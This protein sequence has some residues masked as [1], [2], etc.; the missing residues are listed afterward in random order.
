MLSK[1]KVIKTFCLA[2]DFCIFFDSSKIQIECEKLIQ[3]FASP[4]ELLLIFLPYPKFNTQID[5]IDKFNMVF[6][7]QVII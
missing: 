2:D 5:V 1:S 7:N 4:M 6:E 3:K